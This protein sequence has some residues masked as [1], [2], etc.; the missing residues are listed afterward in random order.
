MITTKVSLT[1]DGASYGWN[2]PTQGLIVFE[3][4]EFD[5]AQ[6]LRF[7][8]AEGWMINSIA[9]LC[10]TCKNHPEITKK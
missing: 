8:S 4:S 6:M 7:A 3:S 1:C 2:C 10:P 5:K 9:H